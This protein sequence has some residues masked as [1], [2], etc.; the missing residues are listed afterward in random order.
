[1][2]LTDEN[3]AIAPCD[4]QPLPVTCPIVNR[5]AD[6]VSYIYLFFYA[7]ISLTPPLSHR[8]YTNYLKMQSKEHARVPRQR[9]AAN[10]ITRDAIYKI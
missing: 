2:M 10:K 6:F 4:A 9:S 1:M 7:S 3:K 8:N 5:E